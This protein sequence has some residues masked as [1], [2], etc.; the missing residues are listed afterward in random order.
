MLLKYSPMYQAMHRLDD[1]LRQSAAYSP[2]GSEQLLAC[3]ALAKLASNQRLGIALDDL[4]KQSDWS[5][6]KNSGLPSSAIKLLTNLF[7]TSNRMASEAA[8]KAFETIEKLSLE[9]RDAPNSAWDVLPYISAADRKTSHSGEFFMAQPVVELMLDML[10]GE[11][12]SVW[13]P[14]DAGGQIAISAYRRGFHVNT[15]S[16]TGNTSLT[17]EL[18]FCIET[19]GVSDERITSEV[20]R[21]GNGRPTVSADF[22]LAV[23]PTGGHSSSPSWQQWQSTDTGS[24][25]RS[26][27]WAVSELLQRARR[28]LIVLTSHTWLFS[29]G[30]E[31]RLRQELINSVSPSLESI[32]TLPGGVF[33]FSNIATA[34]ACFDA[35]KQGAAIR[36]T[37]LA[38][39]G[40][41]RNLSLLD[42][43]D[44]GRKM[45]IGFDGENKISRMISVEEIRDAEYVLLP[46]RLL[47]RAMFNGGNTILLGD[48]C[49]A[50]R[51]TTPYKGSDPLRVLEL[52]IPQLRDAKWSAIGDAYPHEPKT[53]NVK[54]GEKNDVFLR[55]DDILVS[56]KGSLGYAR[57]VSS[58]YGVK[59][60]RAVVS[61]SCIALR[62]DRSSQSTSMTP[63]Y[64]L[65]Y[66]RSAEG[67]EQIKS[68]QVGAA[69]PHISVQ[70]L[71]NSVRIPIP[72]ADEIASVHGDFEKLCSLEAQ[73]ESLA[74]DMGSISESRWF[75]KMA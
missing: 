45:T 13:V 37:N 33:S 35:S 53:I 52:G 21:D 3:I 40:D 63:H 27:A 60:I 2:Y 59:A 15:A 19:A 24:Y 28:R 31:K 10:R 41:E 12:G 58:S 16:I 4:L 38:K 8:V 17:A 67:Q 47:G 50:V 9:L 61:S 70:S 29:A 73:I 71:L 75:V 51:P 42:L 68:L 36:M 6:A 44:I 69:M 46:Q 22:V 48:I 20:P 39:E 66:L 49:T 32:T 1:V 30:Q 74:Q 25:D 72:T 55:L 7:S 14:F 64:L 57:L 54:P 23:P 34:I 26:E 65:M 56:V 5:A 18:L 11:Q 43:V 62:F